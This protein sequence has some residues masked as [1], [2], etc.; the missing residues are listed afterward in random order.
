MK[1]S[2]TFCGAFLP[3]FVASHTPGCDPADLP[4]HGDVPNSAVWTCSNGNLDGS[5]CTKSCSAGNVLKGRKKN[6]TCDC[7]VSLEFFCNLYGKGHN[8]LSLI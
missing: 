1:L 6:T 7:N 4:V 2:S 8:D 3:I 5:V